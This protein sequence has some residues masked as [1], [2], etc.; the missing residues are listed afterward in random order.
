METPEAGAPVLQSLCGQ[1]ESGLASQAWLR[2]TPGGKIRQR[3]G[4]RGYLL[5]SEL[6]DQGLC[7]DHRDI[8]GEGLQVR[9]C[10]QESP[11]QRFQFQYN[12]PI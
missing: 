11:H 8:M 10:D 1:G 5:R 2:I 7:L 4:L 12:S 6:S 9:D 3:T